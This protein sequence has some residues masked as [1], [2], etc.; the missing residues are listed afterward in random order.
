MT[1]FD[2][3]EITEAPKC[4]HKNFTRATKMD[5]DIA[6]LRCR[7]CSQTWCTNLRQRAR[8]EKH[9]NGGCDDPNCEHTHVF[10]RKNGRR[11]RRRTNPVSENIRDDLSE[12][13]PE[14]LEC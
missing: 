2:V 9:F 3:L 11:P 1:G 6:V 12:G 7:Q 4:G 13:P 5:G 10:R 14:L 8:C